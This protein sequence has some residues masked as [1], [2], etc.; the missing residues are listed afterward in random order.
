MVSP[1]ATTPAA[2][3]FSS[4]DSFSL[5]SNKK[6]NRPCCP[7]VLGTKLVCP[8]ESF[9][10]HLGSGPRLSQPPVR[11]QCLRV[12]GS[13]VRAWGSQGHTHWLSALQG[14]QW[15]SL[16]YCCLY[17]EATRHMASSLDSEATTGQHTSAAPRPALSQPRRL[18]SGAIIPEE[19]DIHTPEPKIALKCWPDTRL[20]KDTKCPCELHSP[21]VN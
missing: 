4:S 8:L 17:R 15:H 9:G 21:G 6:V 3:P 18:W 20:V 13:A 2:P 7:A 5:P 11:V 1:T 19:R 12:P 16:H 10:A 14:S